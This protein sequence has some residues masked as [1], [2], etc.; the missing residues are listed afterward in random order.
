[1]RQRF[2]LAPAI[3]FVVALVVYLRTAPPGLTWA[4]NSADGGD[5]IAA[6]MVRGVPHPSGYPTFILLARL[7]TQLAWHTPAWRM[8]LISMLSG[9]A[10][11]AL[12]AAMVQRLAGHTGDSGGFEIASRHPSDE[13]TE[14]QAIGWGS[15]TVSSL[16]FVTPSIVAGLALA[17]SPMLWGQAIV[18]EV[19]ALNTCLAALVMWA[20]VRWR[21]SASPKWA[22]V[23]G[24]AFGAALGNHLTSIW[25][26]PLVAICLTM[27]PVQPARRVR[28]VVSFVLAT[29]AGLL[30]YVYLPLAAAA[31]PPVNWGNPQSA[32]GFWWVI[33]G[34]LYRPF[35]LA[36]GWPEALGRLSAWSSLLWREFLPWGVVLAL[37]GLAWLW[38][39]DRFIALG[40]LVSLALGLSWA[41]GYDTTN[42]LL[43]LLPGWVMISLWI[44][45]GMVWLLDLLQRISTRA[46]WATGLLALT[47]LAVPPILNWTALDLSKDRQAENFLDDVLQAAEPNA[48]IL[49]VGDRATFALWYA[50]YGLERRPDIIP[51]SRDLWALESYRRTVRTTHPAL[52]DREPPAE[53]VTLVSSSLQQRRAV[54]LA[55][56]SEVSAD[57]AE[58]QLAEGSPYR[59]RREALVLPSDTSAGWVLWRLEPTPLFGK[60]PR[61]R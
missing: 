42:S 14:E 37:A 6:A 48:M 2:W 44:G 50:R 34:Q 12:T 36:V 16:L 15:S 17:F 10:A 60:R 29:G 39:A 19:Y 9:A 24:I 25:L 8:T 20:S 35:A 30:V 41:I 54:Y 56:V 22:V 28:A 13:G 31:N 4:H 59:L 49:T 1:M 21:Y 5:L 43:T 18:V 58:P 27:P 33:S 61:T 46:A 7:F 3:V 40:M 26:T 53:L 11:A 45:L 47:L 55:Q 51:I 38:R 23:A 52:A 32:A 57:L